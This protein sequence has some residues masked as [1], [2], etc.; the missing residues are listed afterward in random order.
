MQ[1]IRGS[2]GQTIIEFIVAMPIALFALFGIIYVSRFAVLSERAELALRYGGI[3][4]FTTQSGTYSAGNIYQSI[5]GGNSCPAP[6]LTILA[7]G[8]PLPGPTSAPFWQPDSDVTQNSSCTPGATGF[9]GSQFIASHFWAIT[10][11]N[12]NAGIDVPSYLQAA[13]GTNAASA[14]T[15]ATFIH[16]AYPGIILWCSTEVRNRVESAITAQGSAIPPTPIPDGAPP[17]SP[18][19]NNNGSCN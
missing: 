2:R 17:P 3:A 10:T 5:N 8:G 9:G 13:L 16:S 6:P 1:L 18:P 11:L 14:N 19:P 12:V 15:T 4:A 7:G